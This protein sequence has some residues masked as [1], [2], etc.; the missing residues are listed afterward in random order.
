LEPNARQKQITIKSLIQETTFAYVDERIVDAIVRNLISNAL[1][2]TPAN[3]Y[4]EVAA[5]QN[6]KVL[7]VSISDTGIGISKEDLPKLFRID[8]KY[9]DSGTAGEMGT[10]LGLILC[11]E[12]V[13]KSGGKI[14][15]ES[16]IG[17]GST[18]TFTLPRKPTQV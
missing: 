2:F 5:M 4:V 9:R 12:L 1:K 18:F 6:E 17:E 8:E 3:G 16:E 15:V 7:K 14:W 10:G 11:Q 13:E